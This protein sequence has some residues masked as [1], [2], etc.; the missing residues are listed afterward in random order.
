MSADASINFHIVMDENGVPEK[1]VWNNSD[2]SGTV[3]SDC[4]AIQIRIWEGIESNMANF[5]IW[6]KDMNV[7][8]MNAF[9]YKSFIMMAQG[10]KNATGN[11]QVADSIMQFA[12]AFAETLQIKIDGDDDSDGPIPFQMNIPSEL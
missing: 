12:A 3:S 6:T 10:F 1:V 4:K 8:E 5:D 9:Y 2:Q 7:H 11:A